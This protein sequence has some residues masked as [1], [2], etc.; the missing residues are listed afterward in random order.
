[1]SNTGTSRSSFFSLAVAVV[2]VL[3]TH[4]IGVEASRVCQ[5][6][7]TG[8]ITC[9]EKIG[10]YVIAAIVV[11]SVAVLAVIIA[12]IY[13]V[14]R[15]RAG[16]VRDAEA[17]FAVD[18]S[19]IQGPPI[20]IQQPE[21]VTTYGAPYALASAPSGPRP[22]TLSGVGSAPVAPAHLTLN[23]AS[24]GV[25]MKS[26]TPYG[27]SQNGY[28]QTAPGNRAVFGGGLGSSSAMGDGRYP[29][30]NGISSSQLPPMPASPY[31][32]GLQSGKL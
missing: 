15:T 21:Q 22:L 17:P 19:Q 8:N 25:P 30:S 28:P 24:A 9:R 27:Y 18:P 3:A 4:P 32:S 14:H 23:L 20:M 29:F 26:P 5:T 6:D 10:P 2:W 12:A 13:Y 7:I 11:T 31:S 16:R 1:M